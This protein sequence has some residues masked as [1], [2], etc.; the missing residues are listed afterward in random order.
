MLRRVPGAVAVLLLL[1]HTPAAAQAGRSWVISPGVSIL[2]VDSDADDWGIGPSLAI[3]HDFGVSPSIARRW[4]VE[5]TAAAPAFGGNNAG[6]VAADLGATLTWARTG[7]EAGVA[8]G[9]SALL[10]GDDSEL[11]GGGIGGFVGA[12]GTLWLGP[13]LGLFGEARGRLAG[14]G[15][16]YVSGSAGISVRL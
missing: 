1:A 9:V 10:V 14:V 8:A 13:T 6:G 12:H 5:L 16:A 3:R 2:R 4:G 11:V 7:S 15:G